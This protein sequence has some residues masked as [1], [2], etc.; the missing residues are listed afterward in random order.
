MLHRASVIR[1]GDVVGAE[2]S[3]PSPNRRHLPVTPKQPASIGDALIF[4]TKSAGMV[5]VLA[6]AATFWF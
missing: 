2:R 1:P 3:A 4:M 6:I 5:C